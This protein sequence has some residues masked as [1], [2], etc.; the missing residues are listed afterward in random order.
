M[1]KVIEE[2]II[3]ISKSF[4]SEIFK[5]KTILI[6]GASGFLPAYLV[7]YFLYQNKINT[8]QNTIVIGIVR[9]MKKAERRFKHWKNFNFL[10]LFAQDVSEYFNYNDK[11]DFIIHAASQASPKFYGIDPVG[12]LSPNILGTYNLLKLASEK[13][14]SSF[15]FFSSGEVYGQLN[16]SEDKINE[17]SYGI[18]DPL[19]LRSCYSESKK[20][21]ENICIS[22]SNQFNINCKI[23]RPFHTYGPGMSLNDGRVFADF[24]SNVVNKKDIIINGDGKAIRS[25]CYIKDATIGFLK[26]LIQGN[27]REAYNIGNPSQTFNVL[28]LANI[29]LEL[30]DKSKTNIIFKN[31]KGKGYLKSEYLKVVPNIKKINTLNWYPKTTVREGFKRTIQSFK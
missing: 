27:N 29:I 8:S 13:K 6:S 22:W 15:L 24:V 9:D 5:N 1:N 25:Y 12:T 20:M 21:G 31:I 30:S 4:N 28:E 3:E 7:D 2:D 14:C 26:V 19:N 17:D 18:I 10:K 16:K 23:V 11:I